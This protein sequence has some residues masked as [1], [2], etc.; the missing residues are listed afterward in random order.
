M[1]APLVY[2]SGKHF[3]HCRRVTLNTGHRVL[4]SRVRGLT[5]ALLENVKTFP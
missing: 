4:W 5:W 1:T 3:T 2:R